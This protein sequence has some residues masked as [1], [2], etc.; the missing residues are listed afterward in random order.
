M[1]QFYLKDASLREIRKLI[2]N[3]A[4]FRERVYEAAYLDGCCHIEEYMLSYPWS[5]GISDSRSDYVHIPRWE[6]MDSRDINALEEWLNEVQNNYW[7]LDD[8]EE[9]AI[10]EYIEALR[11]EADNVDDL[12]IDI[13]RIIR[14]RLES[15]LHIDTDMLMEEADYVIGEQFWGEYYV[16]AEWNVCIDIPEKVIPGHTE[17]VC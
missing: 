17:I 13:M 8:Y 7:M 1:K 12:R 5:F 6:N 15:E 10:R 14:E 11:K 2:E 16:D 3:N 9:N 4:A